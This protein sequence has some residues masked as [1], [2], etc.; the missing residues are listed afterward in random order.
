LFARL[1]K[2]ILSVF[3]RLYVPLV[4]RRPLTVLGTLGAPQCSVDFTDKFILS[5]NR[6]SI[7]V[8]I[9]KKYLCEY[10]KA[11]ILAT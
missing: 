6:N 11:F 1:F 7:K 5:G 9:E 8:T 4:V 2:S 3:P 10:L